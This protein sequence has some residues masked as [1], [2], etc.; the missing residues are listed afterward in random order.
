[1]RGGE[2]EKLTDRKESISAFRWS[3]DGRHIALLMTE[4]KTEAQQAREKDKDDARR[5]GERG[6]PARG[7]GTSTSPR[8]R[9]A[10]SRRRRYRIGQI[11][12]TPGG[13]RLIVAASAAPLEDRFN[14]AIF[15]VDLKDGRFTPIA[16]P[17]GPMGAM[18]LSPDGATIAYGCARV[19]G[20]RRTISACS[21]SAGGA[22]RNSTA[23]TIDR[24]INQAKWIDDPTLAISVARGFQTRLEIIASDGGGGQPIPGISAA[25]FPPSHGRAD[26]TVAYVSETAT[27]RAGVVAENAHRSGARGDHRS[28]S[29]GRRAPLIAPR[30]RHLQERRRHRDRSRASEA[31]SPT[32]SALSDGHPRARRPDRPL[33]RQ[34]RAVGTTARD[35]RLR[36]AVSQRPR[37]D[38]LRPSFRRDES[39][40]LGRRRLQ[41]RDGRA[42]TGSS[43]AAS[44]IRIGS[45]SAAGP[46]AATWR[47]GR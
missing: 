35:T 27:E 23:S 39:R 34:L 4:P 45:A 9:S 38:R 42:P 6:S 29:S 19:D 2:A 8:E 47:R 33:G 25:T 43:R 44:P 17:R 36:G 13:D 5:G 10:R 12:F 20:P 31:L 15:A 22:M 41:G 30:V 11:E 14:E 24:P 1:M 28:T 32:P 16:T 46:T 21:R 18:A 37:L 26:G 3:P 7:S 40:R